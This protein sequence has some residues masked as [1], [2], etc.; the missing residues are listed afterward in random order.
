VLAGIVAWS[1]R[2]RLAVLV[3]AAALLAAG[4]VAAARSPLDVFP[5]F[6]PPQ[7]VVQTQAP[8]LSAEDVERLVTLPIERAVNGAPGLDRLQSQSVSGLSVV[9][10]TFA[11]RL[12][13][14]RVRQVISERV[15]RAAASL[16]RAAR[17]PEI[18]PLTSSSGVL[19]VV[20]LT[21]L[22]PP[23]T[24]LA[25][26][27]FAWW[28]VRPRLLAARGVA[29]VVVFGGDER[30]LEVR[31][32]PARLA[33]RGVT[34]D[35]VRRAVEDAALPPP[36]AGFLEDANRRFA[37]EV[38]PPASDAAGLGRALVA[39][40]GDLPLALADVAEVATGAAPRVGDATIDG[41]PGV[42]LVV[43]KSPDASTL[44]ATAE[45]D[46][47]LDEIAPRVPDGAVLRRDLFRQATFIERSIRNMNTAIAA[48]AAL[49]ALVL[50][51]FLAD[52]RT[53]AVS[54]V[55]IPLS[56]L[57]AVL[58]LRAAG[59]TLNTLTLGGLAIAIGEVVDDAIIDVENIHRR[60]RERGATNAFRT[61]LDASLEVR[62]AVVYATFIVAVVFVPVLLLSG[63]QGRLFAP[64][65]TAYVLATLASLATA[66]VVT[67]A[68]A[69]YLLPRA[70]ALGRETRLVRALR[71]RYERALAAMTRR[72]RTVLAIA[73]L[74]F[75]AAAA[76][77]PTFGGTLLPE[78]SQGS[79]VVHM[80][81]VPGTSLAAGVRA[82]AGVE[83][84]LLATG[85]VRTASQRLGRAELGEDAFGSHYGELSVELRDSG[86]DV[87]EQKERI[88]AALA[89]IPGFYF[90][91]KELL[92][93]R[94]E[95]TVGG[96][97]APVVINVF[98]EDL[99]RAEREAA[100]VRAA[101][102]R[103][104]GAGDVR[105]EEQPGA[106]AVRI[107]VDAAATARRGLRPADVLARV[108]ALLSGAEIAELHH[109]E[110]VVEVAIALA[111]AARVAPETLGAL[112]ID[113]PGGPCRLGSLAR[114]EVVRGRA[115]IAHE[116]ARRKVAVLANVAGR[117][118]ESFVADARAA[119]AA[120]HLAPGV[121]TE[122]GGTWEA[123]R[124]AARELLAAG[125]AALVATFLL[126]QSV[127]GS[128]RLAALVLANLPFAFTGGVAVVYMSGSVISVGSLVGFVTL[129]GISTR[130]SILLVA[131]AERLVREEGA[132]FTRETVIRAASER[133][134]PILM[135]AL[136][137]ALGLLPVA[138]SAGRA[139]SEIEAPMALVILG[140]LV[141][142]TALN[143]LLLPALVWRYGRIAQAAGSSPEQP[144]GRSEPALPGSPD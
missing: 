22:R 12:D 98:A 26:R 52:L 14:L 74:L 73:A 142:S 115:A 44:A 29:G 72:P 2:N 119:I 109:G 63:V 104:A 46:R 66:L 21:G 7:V 92:E 58:V 17:P 34:L 82:G 65:A 105:L 139:G 131:H 80:A 127:L 91:V 35:E 76:A 101:V 75:A 56:L 108:S 89:R 20:G 103:L 11:S 1:L 40:R 70:A 110:R 83:R 129:F 111:P 68:L 132:A 96:G 13:P 118:P 144:L 138:L 79:L 87:D 112:T 27:D 31:I 140:G 37:I 71:T 10:A 42:V 143:L 49:V 122:I 55:A 93:E 23:A 117:D 134:S 114:I 125:G 51:V 90:S 120:L 15:A 53:A 86:R 19:L 102:A 24:P 107:E 94:I 16:P 33:A 141:S 121:H 128:A 62:S 133:L 28:T 59:E 50:L 60:L 106:P 61:I 36:P 123:R 32:D 100:R 137:T 43:W 126:L 3:L 136:V 38:A 81:S 8:G 41:H 57:A 78:L 85:E 30:R 77:L 67:P 25:L 135:T 6:V 97:G 84:A 39:K 99:D 54:L 64:L 18:A 48:G 5:E 88:R 116:G 4:M 130:N 124:D 95:E 69:F 9:T 45:V 113:A 47:A